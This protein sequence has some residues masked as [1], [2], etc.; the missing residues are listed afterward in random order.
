MT[1]AGLARFEGAVRSEDLTVKGLAREAL[2]VLLRTRGLEEAGLCLSPGESPEL[3]PEMTGFLKGG[4]LD[5]LRAALAEDGDATVGVA[6]AANLLST[7]FSFI[8][9]PRTPHEL[10]AD[11]E[12][13]DVIA[14][15]Y[16]SK[17]VSPI[18]LMNALRVMGSQPEANLPLFRALLGGLEAALDRSCATGDAGT[19]LQDVASA[20]RS[21]RRPAHKAF[22][23]PLAVAVRRNIPL[24]PSELEILCSPVWDRMSL[25]SPEDLYSETSH[26]LVGP[27]HALGMLR[28]LSSPSSPV[29]LV[30]KRSKAREGRPDIF[31]LT[32]E[33]RLLR[34]ERAPGLAA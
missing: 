25:L 23:G 1:S 18:A 28:G 34:I 5:Y 15:L 33:G 14:A 24:S 27:G 31:S 8:Q 26:L 6:E 9:T 13:L 20:L 21:M 30:S 3:S 29:R 12:M 17:P 4:V 10:L 11:E 16:R 32:E 2:S 19:I 22:F 7:H